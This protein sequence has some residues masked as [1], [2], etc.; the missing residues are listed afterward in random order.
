MTVARRSLRDTVAVS[1]SE[2]MKV[3]S[4][5]TKSARYIF[6]LSPTSLTDLNTIRS[7]DFGDSPRVRASRESGHMKQSGTVCN[8]KRYKILVLSS[9]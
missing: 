7:V 8:V 1:P 3:N 4:A 5:Q 6:V 2:S 9:M